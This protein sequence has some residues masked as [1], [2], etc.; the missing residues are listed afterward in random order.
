MENATINPSPPNLA[1]LIW[2]TISRNDLAALVELAHT[3]LLI[4]GGL[5]FLFEPDTLLSRYFPDVPGRGIGAFAPDERLVACATVYISGDSGTQRATTVGQVRP[6]L[7]NQGIGTYLMRWSQVQA[8]ALLAG[9]ATN[10]GVLQVSTESLTEPAHKLYHAHGFEK[11]F[12]ELVMRR[13]LVLPVPDR[14]LPRSVTITSWQ[15]ELAEQ[16]YQAYHAA[17]RERPGF[18]GWSAAEWIA[19]VTDNDLIPEWTLLARAGGVPLGFVIGNIDLTTVPPG[20]F[21]WQIGVIPAQ[22]RRGLGSALMVETM[23]RMQAEGAAWVQLAVHTNNPGA[24]ETYSQ[25]GFITIGRRARYERIA[26]Q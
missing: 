9:A 10:P 22:R 26:E 1:G 15:P 11:V 8:Q 21:V 2:R 5:S 24:I 20:G 7:R 13:D 6:D 25:L 17:F 19:Q 18:P 23:R 12:E 16:F 4:D 14:A 3:C